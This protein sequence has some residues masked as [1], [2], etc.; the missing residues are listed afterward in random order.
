M[1]IHLYH[2]E[3]GQGFP[4]VLLH[5]NGEDHTYFASQIAFFSTHYHVIA[6]DTRG[7]GQSP[8]GSQPF[9]ISQFAAD[10]YKFFQQKRLKKAHILGFSDG[11]NIALTFA[12]R[13]PEYVDHLILNGANLFP[14][15][16]KRTVQASIVLGYC[17]AAMLPSAKARHQAE[18]L[19]LMIKEPHL[20]PSDL[21]KLLIPTLVIA[22]TKDMIRTSHTHLIAQNLP[23]SQLTILPGSHFIARETADSFNQA[24]EAFLCAEHG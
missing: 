19:A 13:H 7:H 2:E 17:L 14:S 10:L 23:N 8:R 3:Y 18:L 4:L 21:Q 6:I 24:V 16:L 22:G 12:L 15:G 9:T 5:G 1:D 20:L 11:G